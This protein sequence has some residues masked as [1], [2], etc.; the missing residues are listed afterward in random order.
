MSVQMLLRSRVFTSTMNSLIAPCG[1]DCFE[2]KAYIATQN[3]DWV[4]L[5]KL[6]EEWTSDEDGFEY[7]QEEMICDGCFSER[8]N[9]FCRD[10]VVRLCAIERG[11]TIC[12]QCDDYLCTKLESH[13]NSFSSYSPDQLRATLDKLREE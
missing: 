3:E 11:H 13:W 6:A 4:S 9:K 1:I 10:C 8:V 5:Q 7:T 2:C 12:S